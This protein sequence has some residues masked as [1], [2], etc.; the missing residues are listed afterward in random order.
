[1]IYDKNLNQFAKHV[2]SMMMKNLYM[3]NG[4]GMK[5]FSRKG[6]REFWFW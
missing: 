1:M 3:T 5:Q 2:S 6:N 4:Y